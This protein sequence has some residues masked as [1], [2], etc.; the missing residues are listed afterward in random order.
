MLQYMCPCV[1]TFS[2]IVYNR[3]E[4]MKINWVLIISLKI[5]VDAAS[6]KKTITLITSTLNSIFS[7]LPWITEL[8]LLLSLKGG[9]VLHF[10]LKSVAM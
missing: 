9:G 6:R 2:A 7:E 8:H 4:V 1:F 5:T 3:T 10:L